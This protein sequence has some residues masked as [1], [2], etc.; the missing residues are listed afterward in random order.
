M[1]P[2]SVDAGKAIDWY[3]FGWRIF[4]TNPGLWIALMLLIAVIALILQIIPFVGPLVLSLI[5]PALAGGLMYGAK[6]AAEGR[7]IEIAHLFKGLTDDNTRGPL[8]ILGAVLLGLTIVA[9]M[10]AIII[11]GGSVG[12]V[13]GAGE[14]ARDAAVAVG[15][16][17]AGVMLTFVIMAV[18]GL[19]TFAVLAFAIPLVTFNGVPP[20]EA[21]K[22][23]VNASLK[24]VVTLL[25]FLVIYFVLAVIASIPIFLGFL[26]LAPVTAAALYAAYRDVFATG[27]ALSNGAAGQDFARPDR[28]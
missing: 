28:E 7:S 12:I 23:S 21:I 22:S 19:A 5:S 13:G 9:S 20:I 4:R 24:N 18:Y 26:V 25:V 14:E 15:A 2:Q 27:A 3:S 1:Q 16:L 11:I 6:E 10:V 8:L 17:G